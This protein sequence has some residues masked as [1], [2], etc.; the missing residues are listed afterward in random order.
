MVRA[1]L[2]AVILTLGAV[3]ALAG[4]TPGSGGI[5][6]RPLLLQRPPETTAAPSPYPMTY[7]EQVARRL[8]LGAGGVD[9]TPR[10]QSNPYAPSVSFN[11]SMLRLKWRP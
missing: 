1:A 3:P 9:L 11:G 2:L 4:P 5:V 8:G 6:I 10:E 7:T